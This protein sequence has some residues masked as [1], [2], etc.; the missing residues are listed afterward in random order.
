MKQQCTKPRDQTEGNASKRRKMDAPTPE[1][2][3]ASH[4]EGTS[5]SNVP[6][7][8][9]H[10]GNKQVKPHA[11]DN[12][13]RSVPETIEDDITVETVREHLQRGTPEYIS[14]YKLYLDSTE[15]WRNWDFHDRHFYHQITRPGPYELS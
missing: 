14:E 10:D 3:A 13:T 1:K 12:N 8:S 6:V 4:D 15:L 11:A 7:R 9:V 5:S 2:Q